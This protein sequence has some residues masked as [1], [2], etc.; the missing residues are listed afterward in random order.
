MDVLR[1]VAGIDPRYLNDEEGPCPW[2]GGETRFRVIDRDAGA[3]RC[4]HCFPDSCGDPR[5]IMACTTALSC[6][7]LN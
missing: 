3:V 6:R 2:C 5:V 7:C 1:D 4:S